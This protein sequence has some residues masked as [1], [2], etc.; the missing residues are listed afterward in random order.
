M[1]KFC[2]KCGADLSETNGICKKCSS[3][4]QFSSNG[5]IDRKA[6][7]EEAKKRISGNIFNIL[8]PLLIIFGISFV[9]GIVSGF[10]YEDETTSALIEFI[11]GFVTMPLTMGTILYVLKFVRGEEYSLNN[12]FEFYD[13]RILTIFA[14]SFLVGLFTMLWSLLFII[15]GIIAAISY[16]MYSFIYV[17]GTITDP[18]GVIR[19]SKRMMSG[20][21]W[22]Y[23][24]FQLSFI[25]WILLVAMS[26][27]IALIYVMPYM[28]VS[29][30]LYYDELKKIKE[31]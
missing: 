16:S 8:K 27:G 11:V 18:M 13:S 1:A 26:L 23:F 22:D 30:T 7:K 12:V 31:N 25:G 28:L 21:K 29:E 17:D 15:P 19:E 2:T 20:Y 5:I 4:L 10:F 9:L 24:V 3:S 6:I 14:L